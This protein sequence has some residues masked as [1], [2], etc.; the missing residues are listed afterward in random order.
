MSFSD[1]RFRNFYTRFDSIFEKS[2]IL[3]YEQFLP[4]ISW[5]VHLAQSV[6]AATINVASCSLD[7][8]VPRPPVTAGGSGRLTGKWVEVQRRWTSK[9]QLSN[10]RNFLLVFVADSILLLHT[11]IHLYQWSTDAKCIIAW[12]SWVDDR[13]RSTSHWLLT[14]TM[15]FQSMRIAAQV[16]NR[17]I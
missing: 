8:L 4:S 2:Q 9:T 16:L 3:N 14:L 10:Q 13:C 11:C 1:G 12:V 17:K 15:H 6:A 5:L 7:Y